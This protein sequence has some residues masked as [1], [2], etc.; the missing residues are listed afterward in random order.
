MANVKIPPEFT[1]DRDKEKCITCQA[2][3][4]VCSNDVHSY[5]EE[6][7]EVVSD[8][9]KCV[10][11]HFCESLCPTN[12]IVIRHNPSETRRNAQWTG[13]AMRDIARQTEIAHLIGGVPGVVTIRIQDEHA[14]AGLASEHGDLLKVLRTGSCRAG[15]GQGS[16]C[17]VGVPGVGCQ[18]KR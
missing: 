8:A 12:A 7:A 13:R 5:D 4:R 17:E 16:A 11:C 18:D 10:G 9:N 3:Y 14:A 1:V 6:K 2:C 15:D